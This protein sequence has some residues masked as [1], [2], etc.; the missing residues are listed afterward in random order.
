MRKLGEAELEQELFKKASRSDYRRVYRWLLSYFKPF[1]G[2][3]GL[4]LICGG[5]TILGEIMIPRQMGDMIDDIF[6]KNDM[7]LLVNPLVMMVAIIVVI[8][9]SKYVFNLLKVKIANGIARN[10]Q[11]DLLSQLYR[12]GFSFYEAVPTGKI[13]SLFENSVKEVQL[14]Y[15]FL[16]PHFIYSL[17]QF[18]VPSIVLIINEPFFFLVTMVGNS[19]FVV[20]NK[21]TNDKIHKFLNEET[22]KAHLY[23][24]S[25]YNAI[26]FATESKAMGN[27]SWMIDKTLKHYEDY[28]SPRMKSIFWRHFRYTTVGLTLTISLVLFY[29]VG[30]KQ[31]QSGQMLLGDFITYSFYIALVSRGFSV[32]FYIIPAQEH[33]LHYAVDLYGLMQLEPQVKE[34]TRSKTNKTQSDIDHP[35]EE[36]HCQIE[37][38]HTSFSYPVDFLKGL[39]QNHFGHNAQDRMVIDSLSLKIQAGQKVALVGESGC[40][41]STVLKLLGRFYD[42]DSG[43]IKLEGQDIKLM[44]LSVLR[45]KMGYVFQETYLLNTTIMENIRWGNLEASDEAV[46]EAAQKSGAHEFILSCDKGYQTMVGERGVNLSGGQKQRISIART[47]LKDPEILLLDEATS[48]LDQKT[49]YAIK[50]TIDRIGAHKT[51]IAVAHRLETIKEFDMIYVLDK[52]KIIEQ[53]NYD[54][55]MSQKGKF[56]QL[57]INGDA[58]E[59]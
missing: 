22:E 21:F 43:L 19:L 14:T 32:F 16:F 37:F 12:L 47:L 29:W 40:G 13:L 2:L 5:I 23:Q 39:G 52:G 34:V 9:L 24:E 35:V 20:I 49:E 7:S 50:S 55:L 38:D 57:V 42:I 3:T 31:I 48:A 36:S 6:P 54:I 58:Y 1:W 25:L 45:Q 41:K 30:F 59:A 18:L 44:P 8:I 10:Q 4:Y 15:S 46:I 26:A 56:Y 28:R 51:V 33:A 53:G 11:K 17:S 27:Q